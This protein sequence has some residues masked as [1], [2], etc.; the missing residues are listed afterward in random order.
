[1]VWH[2]EVNDFAFSRDGA[3][4]GISSSGNLSFGFAL[5]FIGIGFGF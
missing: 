5:I 1:V 3:F 4:D 2:F